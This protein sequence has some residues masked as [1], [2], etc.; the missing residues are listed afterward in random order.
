MKPLK[1]PDW[2]QLFRYLSVLLAIV[3]CFFLARGLYGY[4][5]PPVDRAE[6]KLSMSFEYN[7]SLEDLLMLRA[8]DV[9][10]FR[11]LSAYVVS[12]TRYDASAAPSVG[13][14]E[15]TWPRC[16]DGLVISLVV[17]DRAYGPF[18]HDPNLLSPAFWSGDVSV[19]F[20][21]VVSPGPHT[22]KVIVTYKGQPVA[23]KTLNFHVPSFEEAVRERM[24]S[25]EPS[26]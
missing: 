3:G 20:K 2:A 12:I 22:L 18:C 11:D 25:G 8:E 19:D 24:G 13:V 17:D 1:Y 21:L 14:L 4:F 15:S 9:F 26:S 7:G 5:T 6:V 23:S 10:T 16:S